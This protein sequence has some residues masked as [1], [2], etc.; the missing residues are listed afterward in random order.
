[1][2]W[3]G[4]VR[5]FQASARLLAVL[6]IGAGV[7]AAGAV[8]ADAQT[9]PAPTRFR[10]EAVRHVSG[11]D[12]EVDL[13]WLY[14]TR[15]GATGFTVRY[16]L[17]RANPYPSCD[18]STPTGS[19]MDS[20]TAGGGDRRITIRTLDRETSACF[21]I[22]AD[23]AGA[24]FSDWT[25]VE[26]SPIDLRDETSP[27]TIPAPNRPM[28]YAG[29][30]RVTVTFAPAGN[31]GV[32]HGSD[33][34]GNEIRWAYA[35]WFYTRRLEGEP[36]G[37]DPTATVEARALAASAGGNH[38]VVQNIANGNSYVF[39]IRLEC[40]AAISP[41][42]EES[43][44]VTPRGTDEEITEPQGLRVVPVRVAGRDTAAL[45]VTWDHPTS[46]RPDRYRLQ[47]RR[48]AMDVTDVASEWTSVT[49]P[50]SSGSYDIT[51]LR[52]NAEYEIWLRA[53][54]EDARPDCME[55]AESVDPC[56]PWATIS[57]NT[58]GT[59]QPPVAVD[60]VEP[61]VLEVEITRAVDVAHYFS[62]PD[63][64][65]L[66]F[67]A[68]SQNTA[69]VTAT[70]SGS[71]VTI[72]AVRAGSATVSVS[73]TDPGGLSA[74]IGIEVTVQEEPLAAVPAV[75]VDVEAFIGPAGPAVLWEPPA[76]VAGVVVSGYQVSW[77]DD[78]D[79]VWEDAVQVGGGAEART[80]APMV[81]A[82]PGRIYEFRVRALSA[83]GTGPWSAP[84]TVTAP[85]LSTPSAPVDVEAFIGPD[86]P[87][88]LWEPPPPVAGAVVTG[89]E[90]SW[91]D[92]VDRVWSQA[93]HVGGGAEARTWTPMVAAVPGRTYEFRVRALSDD[94]PGPWSA[95]ATVDAPALSIPSSPLAV[96]AFV[97]PDGPAVLWEPPPP[98]AG[99]DIIRYDV[100][101]RTDVNR[102]WTDYS[103]VPGGANA[104]T[105]APMV[106]A[107]PGRT[108]EFRVR[109]VSA[110]G[111]GA[112]SVPAIVAVPELPT[113]SAP[114][115]LRLASDGGDL[116]ATWDEPT[117][118]DSI[119]VTG[120]TLR[121]RGTG[122]DGSWR[123][124]DVRAGTLR[125]RIPAS[126][127]LV[128]G[129]TYR[130][131][132]RALGAGGAGPWS[133]EAE[134]TIPELILPGLPIWLEP[135]EV[136]GGGIALSWEE[137]RNAAEATVSGYEVAIWNLTAVEPPSSA[138]V[139]RRSDQ[140]GHTY[141]PDVIPPGCQYTARV[142]AV[143]ENGRGDYAYM[144][145][146][147][148]SGP[149]CGDLLPSP[150]TGV[151][152][153]A[154]GFDELARTRSVSVTWS[155]GGDI[156][157][158]FH[159]IR[160][161]TADGGRVQTYRTSEQPLVAP[162]P[163]GRWRVEAQAG[164]TVAGQ[165]GHSAWSEAFELEVSEPPPFLVSLRDITVKPQRRHGCRPY[166]GPVEGEA[167][168]YLSPGPLPYSVEAEAASTGAVDV[169]LSSARDLSLSF[170]FL[171][172]EVTHP[173]T[174]WVDCGVREGERAE[175]GITGVTPP[176]RYSGRVF[177]DPAVH[178]VD[179]GDLTPVPSVPAAA[180]VLLGA[181]LAGLGAVR[182][183][184][185]S[186][187]DDP[188]EGTE[189]TTRTQRPAETRTAA[190]TRIE[191]EGRPPNENQPSRDGDRPAKP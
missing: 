117:D 57:G 27:G 171:P 78:V 56:G 38:P 93:V 76:P 119:P 124:E 120:Y 46:G 47:Y 114:L 144:P 31:P 158:Q 79:R 55:Q 131:Q 73:A 19:Q 150:P 183:R 170:T 138:N 142:R 17:S 50:G 163:A 58:G 37:D 22:R 165:S 178:E 34:D 176:N 61:I 191:P 139:L 149:V 75:P 113:P 180:V 145:A 135:M 28:V 141:Q 128:R 43:E 74:R 104:R 25:L 48:G 174:T 177:A 146:A 13:T 70:I 94:R 30:A 97:G 101:W 161:S 190:R 179:V 88:V 20:G 188:S 89:Y 186:R 62:D 187:L 6:G 130:V 100:S 90:V 148:L 115:N 155:Q 39:K 1:M 166:N 143:G 182:L 154:G 167:E 10:V 9:R 111:A 11:G 82:V 92:D 91:R 14:P 95:P 121:F 112:W 12:A 109:A 29:D 33:A 66:M 98:V 108:Y 63:G 60:E 40:Q 81:A 169:Q 15:P 44:V 68:F 136:A 110:A 127:G 23:F 42:S 83:A 4:Q 181:V 5:S 36:F 96:E 54:A 140:L 24:Q 189:T 118:I 59:N 134:T 132:V 137:P 184:R 3:R 185:V 175:V 125:S 21:W 7:L 159:L 67:S 45:T 105:W 123:T 173:L 72:K 157:A 116:V 2:L 153:E 151:E 164:V 71:T 147:R 106:A 69:V 156:D 122:M 126:Y 18:N 51:G 41:W 160:F 8:P 152:A 84:A 49:L 53:E 87:A 129:G 85:A 65:T 133:A 16:D 162:R 32:C 26:S 35:Q 102:A 172:G 168:A 99:A 103:S 64:D 52:F 80:W 107:V 77:R 86:G